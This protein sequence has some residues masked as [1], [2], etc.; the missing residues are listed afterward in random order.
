MHGGATAL[1]AIVAQTRIERHGAQHGLF[2]LPGLALA[3]V[4]HSLFNQFV[5]PPAV[6]AIAVLILL[7]LILAGVYRRSERSL[8]GWLGVGFDS[9]AALLEMINGGEILQTRVGSYLLSLKQRF[10]GPVVADMLCLLRLHLELSIRAK[11]MLLMREAG[12]AIPAPG[13]EVR[14]RFAELRYLER[15]VGKT[16]LLAAMPILRWSRRDLWQMTILGKR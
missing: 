13:A 4:V 7:P 10:P 1:C 6:S 16:G 5:L 8:Q 3:I 15:S 14:E 2:L 12:F 11:G 9:D